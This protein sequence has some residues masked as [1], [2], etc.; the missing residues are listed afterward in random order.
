MTF[1]HKYFMSTHIDYLK[2]KKKKFNNMIEE[3]D[4]LNEILIKLEKDKL[5]NDEI[6]IKN[7]QK[8]LASLKGH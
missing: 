6:C 7:K 2:K 5:K 1:F 4:S 3:Y 8:F